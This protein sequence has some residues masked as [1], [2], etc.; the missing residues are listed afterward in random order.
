MLIMPGKDIDI[1]LIYFTAYE[2]KD[3]V[4]T[5]EYDRNDPSALAKHARQVDT[6]LRDGLRVHEWEGDT[7]EP[8]N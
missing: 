7:N 4:F 5:G 3:P 2:D 1:W 6:F 8:T